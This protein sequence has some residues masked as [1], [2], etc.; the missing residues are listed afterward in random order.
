MSPFGVGSGE[1]E[2]LDYQGP[3]LGSWEEAVWDCQGS[4]FPSPHPPR[5]LRSPKLPPSAGQGESCS[6]PGWSWNAARPELLGP[7]SPEFLILRCIPS[8]PIVVR[9]NNQ[10]SP[11]EGLKCP[12]KK[13][14]SCL[15]VGVP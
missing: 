7:P 11:D 4:L 10:E 3:V 12:K 2:T 14:L 15:L 6:F 9:V 8:P 1:L 5:F 13:L